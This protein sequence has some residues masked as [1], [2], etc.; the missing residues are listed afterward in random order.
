MQRGL[1]VQF[2][3]QRQRRTYSTWLSSSLCKNRFSMK[4]LW[5]KKKVELLTYFVL[6]SLAIPSGP[7][8]IK[9]EPLRVLDG[10]LDR[11][12]HHVT[13]MMMLVC[14]IDTGQRYSA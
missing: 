12:A 10:A 14:S 8:I 1:T 6:S 7:S 4:Q 9:I 5:K 2:A 3:N 11:T 13:G